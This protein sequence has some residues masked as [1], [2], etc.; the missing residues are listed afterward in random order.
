MTM[1]FSPL[2]CWTLASIYRRHRKH[3]S[4]I[5]ARL[6][7]IY[8]GVLR[9]HTGTYTDLLEM[10]FGRRYLK[11][12]LLLK[13]LLSLLLNISLCYCSFSS[14]I[15]NFWHI[16]NLAIARLPKCIYHLFN[17]IQFS[18]W[19]NVHSSQFLVR[20]SFF[21]HYTSNTVHIHE[22]C[23]NEWEMRDGV[24]KAKIHIH[25]KA[26]TTN[27]RLHTMKNIAQNRKKL[28]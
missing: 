10:L 16:R 4:H 13:A 28:T 22:E 9:T 15:D 12:Q 27:T 26:A 25:K 17:P 7:I 11:F 24:R 5:A 1:Y 19:I 2:S 21:I 3:S 6:S 8:C 20:L 14:A 23:I 18:K